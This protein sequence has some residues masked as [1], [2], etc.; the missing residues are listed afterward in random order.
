[1]LRNNKAFTMAEVLITLGVIGIV[2]AM[3]LP[4]LINKYQ[5]TQFKSAYKKAYSEF[6]QV[7]QSSII[8]HE[9]NRT[10]TFEKTATLEELNLMKKNFKILKDC[11]NKNIDRCWKKGDSVCGGSCQSG[12]SSD[13]IDLNDG[14]PREGYANCF[15]DISGRSWCSYSDSEN[16]YLVDTNGFSNPNQFGKDRW[17]FTFADSANKRVNEGTKYKKIIPYQNKDITTQSSFC[18]RPPCYYQSW[19][20]N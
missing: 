18:K 5:E 16:I 1:M 15:V 20:L 8:N 10:T 19:L 2:A 4:T 9:F 11:G 14:A 3:T 12:D 6:S 13:G 7:L 17:L